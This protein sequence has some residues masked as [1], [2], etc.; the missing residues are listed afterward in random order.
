[1]PKVEYL[2]AALEELGNPTLKTLLVVLIRRVA[3]FPDMVQ[4]LEAV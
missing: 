1:M 3:Q 2:K 4:R